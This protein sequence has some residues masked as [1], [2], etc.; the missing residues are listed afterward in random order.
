MRN[1][2]KDEMTA[3]FEVLKLQREYL[4]QTFNDFS[5]RGLTKKQN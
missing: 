2:P 3:N 1:Y 5:K 4:Y